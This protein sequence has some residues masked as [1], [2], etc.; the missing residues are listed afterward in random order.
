MWPHLM[1]NKAKPRHCALESLAA[2]A[3]SELVYLGYQLHS[4][5]LAL[6]FSKIAVKTRI[7]DSKCRIQGYVCDSLLCELLHCLQEEG[8]S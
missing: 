8:S 5:M 7:F 2:Y 1:V 3:L 6:Y 4:W